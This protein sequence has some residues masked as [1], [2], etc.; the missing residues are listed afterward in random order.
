MAVKMFICG[1]Y[2]NETGKVGQL[3]LVLLVPDD[4]YQSG[5]S[6]HVAGKEYILGRRDIIGKG[7]VVSYEMILRSEVLEL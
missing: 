6:I 7:S 2:N 3:W 4:H 1:A 5:N